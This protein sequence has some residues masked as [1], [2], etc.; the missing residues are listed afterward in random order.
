MRPAIGL[1]RGVFWDLPASLTATDQPRG[2]RTWFVRFYSLHFIFLPA[3]FLRIIDGCI[4]LLL[5]IS[6]FCLLSVQ[7][8][9]LNGALTWRYSI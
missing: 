5:Y 7:A 4:F 8:S 2:R 1:K 9:S 3:V 6:L